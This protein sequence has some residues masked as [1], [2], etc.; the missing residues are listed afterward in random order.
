MDNDEKNDLKTLVLNDKDL[1]V[2]NCKYPFSRHRG[3]IYHIGLNPLT[4]WNR[5]RINIEINPKDLV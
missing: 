3:T 1:Y 2:F 4:D 5:I